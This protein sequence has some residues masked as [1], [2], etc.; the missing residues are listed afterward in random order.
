M[1]S[2]EE[3]ENTGK[4]KQLLN[5]ADLDKL[6]FMELVL[7]IDVRNTSGKIP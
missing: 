7:S 1:Q 4:G 2:D 5:V 3:L 6:A